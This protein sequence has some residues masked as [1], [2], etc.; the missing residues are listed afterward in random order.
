MMRRLLL[1]LCPVLAF[2]VVACS[3]DADVDPKPLPEGPDSGVRPDAGPEP[4]GN[5]ETDIVFEDGT[6]FQQRECTVTIRFASQAAEAKIAGEFTDWAANPRPMTRSGDAFEITL[7]P[8]DGLTPGALHAYKLIEGDTWRLDPNGTH[9]KIIDGQMNSALRAPACDAGPELRS[10][11]V[12]VTRSGE[13]GEMKVRVHVRTA[14]DGDPA[15]R[16]MASLDRGRIPEGS[17]AIDKDAGAVDF[18]FPA[19]PK[20]KHTLSLRGKDKKG[21]DAEPI[22]LAFW[23]EDEPFDYR[24]GLIYMFMMDRFANGDRSNDKP[25]GAPVHYD[26][27][28]HGGDLQGAL[29]VMK[30]G[31]FEKMGVRTIW[32][33]P[34][35][36][37]TSKYESGDGN[38]LYSAY[39]GYWP[40]KAREVE[41]R[42]G[43]GA[44]MHAF[45][46]EAHARGLRVLL[47]LINN[48]VHKDHEYLAQNGSWFRQ[49][50]KCGD[51]GCGW[52][53]R[54]FDCMFAPYLPDIDWTQAGAEKQ[55]IDDALSWIA[56]YDFDGFRV[57]AVKHV[58]ANSIYNMR[59]ELARRFE[60]GGARIFM[61][62]ETAVGEHDGGNFFGEVFGSGFEWIDA[63]TGPT[64][65]DGQFD[66]PTRHNMADGLVNGK[67][68]L[69]EVEGELQ[70]A[71]N[72]YRPNHRHV[73][74]L[75]G[76]DNPRIASIAAED[77]KLGCIWSSGCRDGDL[78]PLAYDDPQIYVRLKRALTVLYTLPGVPFLY[79]GDE[80][81]FGGGADPDMRR[82]M[83]FA[84]PELASVQ[85]SKPGLMPPKLTAKQIEL[86]DW[87]RKLGAT[88]TASRPLRRGARTT[89]VADADFWAYAYQTGPKEIAVVALN[90][91]DSPVVRTAS[92][93]SLSLGGVASWQAA[94]GT[95]S[96][97]N[98]DGGLQISLAAGE[99]A[100]FIAK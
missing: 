57:D 10:E 65:L 77:P 47:D 23:V 56:E 34:I 86:R 4:G 13:T 91:S 75:N 97:T 26:A 11:T 84:E 94:L 81:A 25:V 70:K 5:E 59:A 64:A 33:S 80:V 74:F 32:L 53:E 19:L 51:Q 54:P 73:R 66:F 95:G 62:G 31:Y 2:V 37:Q 45:V 100:I 79:A 83:L 27:D 92:A 16:L 78:P 36:A 22:D 43:G 76:H 50:C 93:G 15:D 87:V 60:Q 52:S 9:R 40:I 17:Y 68:P 72:A 46:K 55:F 8:A 85:M 39:H 12:A 58:E 21:R 14:T 63:Y 20:G 30:T 18:T 49:S 35:N 71:E 7:S 48:Q 82:D 42:F 29:A 96:A 3:S 44:A 67:K 38:Q 28:W 90:R 24:D 1:S 98:A 61:V 99:A 88:R 89:L 41:P 69:N 6:T